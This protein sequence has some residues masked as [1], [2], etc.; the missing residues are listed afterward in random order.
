M[1]RY[2]CAGGFLYA[3]GG[4]NL[5]VAIVDDDFYVR[6]NIVDQID[7]DKLGNPNVKEF[8]DG[9]QLIEYCEKEKIDIVVCDI[10]MPKYSGV[11]AVAS[12]LEKRPE[13]KIIFISGY[14]EKGFLISAIKLQAV[15]FLEK[16][17]N[18]EEL[19]STL[20]EVVLSKQEFE[21]K[22]LENEIVDDIII[23]ENTREAAI[24]LCS[25]NGMSLNKDC[26]KIDFKR[27][28]YAHFF[29]LVIDCYED[30]QF[31]ILG[32][33]EKSITKKAKD[34]FKNEVF[35]FEC[36]KDGY[37]VIHICGPFY[38]N[39]FFEQKVR[40]V[41]RVITDIINIHTSDFVCGVGEPVNDIEDVYISYQQAVIALKQCFFCSPGFIFFYHGSFR[42]VWN[43]DNR[44]VDEFRI[45]ISSYKMKETKRV[46]ADIKHEISRNQNNLVNDVISLY[47]NLFEA[48][49]KI[50]KD[51]SMQL[52]SEI[53]NKKGLFD[54]LSDMQFYSDIHAYI[55]NITDRFFERYYQVQ[56]DNTYVIKMVRYIKEN[57][58]NSH[59][60]VAN[61]ADIVNFS[62]N[63]ANN[64]FKV[65]MDTTINNYINDTRLNSAYTLLMNT[66]LN[67][68]KISQI[69]GYS[70]IEYF[71]RVFR[72]TYKKSP[73]EFRR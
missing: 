3:W 70:S 7:W 12:M 72:R 21:R 37:M 53:K 39:G 14:P 20:G 63:Y 45:A 36:I 66:Q 22:R 17:L 71:S 5:N 27:D 69:T 26:E 32:K 73:S 48:L 19:Q 18:I 67:I 11:D 41:L 35:I 58:A 57:Y 34:I 28:K 38:L 30:E 1:I 42:P 52:F 51:L 60:C 31:N 40:A 16:P 65:Y 49:W 29:S 8:E 2:D 61:V 62:P 59:I 50:S 64:L 55:E 15:N 10:M 23:R 24:S 68:S 44:I 47:I 33:V 54:Y 43:L 46:L 4:A 9:L 13:V 25:K 56:C 6:K